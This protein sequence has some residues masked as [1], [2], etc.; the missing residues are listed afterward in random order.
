MDYIE[1]GNGIGWHPIITQLKWKTRDDN[2]DGL[3]QDYSNTSALAME[4][5]QSCTK[6][7]T[8]SSLSTAGIR[9]Y[10]LQYSTSRQSSQRNKSFISLG[11]N[12]WKLP[13]QQ[14]GAAP[15]PSVVSV[16]KAE[17]D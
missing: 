3:V 1:A 13:A 9:M 5:V 14:L 11:L 10:M 6:P 4:L 2:I 16:T 7:S 17:V 12:S 15:R 8:Y